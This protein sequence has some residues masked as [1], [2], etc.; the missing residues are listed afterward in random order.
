MK[1][2][3]P[4]A[5]VFIGLACV[6]ALAGSLLQLPAPDAVTMGEAIA[7]MRGR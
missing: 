1:P 4:I 3:R 2:A 7:M 6:L 5:P